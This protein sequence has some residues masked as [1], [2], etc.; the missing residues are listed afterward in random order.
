MAEDTGLE[1]VLEINLGYALAVQPVT[2]PAI[3]LWHA[4]KESNPQPSDLESAALPN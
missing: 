2:I 3:F 4:V 1:P